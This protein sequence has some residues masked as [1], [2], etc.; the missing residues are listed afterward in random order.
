MSS[1][2]GDTVH[3]IALLNPNDRFHSEAVKLSTAVSESL[4]TTEWVLTEV[5]DAFC[6]PK[7]RPRF[8]RL[9]EL[10]KSQSDVQILPAT[11]EWFEAGVK[12]FG[13]RPDKEWSLTDCIS[14]AIMQERKIT[15]VLTSD[16]HFEQAGFT[17]L[18]K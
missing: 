10:L 12:L 3:F 4:I 16:H 17:I 9:L 8:I 1:I 6:L 2:F 14:M 7:A 18:L 13:S 15:T 5:G 11:T